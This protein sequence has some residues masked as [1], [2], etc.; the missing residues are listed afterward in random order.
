MR[1]WMVAPQGLC[2]KH[3]VAE[4]CECHMFV[5]SILK[6]RSILGHITRGQFDA[7]NLKYRHDKLAEEMVRRGFNH[8]TPLVEPDFES[9]CTD[10]MISPAELIT[11]IDVDHN[12]TELVR[13]CQG[14]RDQVNKVLDHV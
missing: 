1:M 8:A 7:Q 5:G 10:M 4:H 3:L 11:C 14:C 9:Y 2:T 13:R 6:R 12:Q